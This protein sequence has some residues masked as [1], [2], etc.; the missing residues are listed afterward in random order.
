MMKVT[1][2]I[3]SDF[4][5]VDVDGTMRDFTRE[6]AK[7]KRN[8]FPVVDSEDN[9]YGLIFIND[10]RNII[11]NTD[12]WD[13]TLVKDLMYM[14]AIT[15]EPDESME[16]VAQKFQESEDYNL[17]VLRDGKYMGFVSRAQVFMTYRRLL[18]EFSDE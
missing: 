16:S 2:M 14:P 4:R 5:T 9:F 8:I 7:S 11:F 1:S 18:K 13:T 12:L 17:P 3:E 15:V 6:V 10:I